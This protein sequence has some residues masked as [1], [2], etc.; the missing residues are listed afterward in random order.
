L[1]GPLR[2]V[3]F[4]PPGVGKGTQAKALASKLGAIWVSTGEALRAVSSLDTDEGRHIKTLVE[5]G[6]LIPDELVTDIVREGIARIVSIGDGFILDGYPRTPAQARQ[7]DEILASNDVSLHQ[8][9]LLEAPSELLI[10]RLLRRA[11]VEG[12]ADDTGEV[13][14]RRLA[15]YE[16]ELEQ[17]VSHYEQ[18]GTLVRVDGTADPETVTTTIA[19]HLVSAEA[20][21][22]CGQAVPSSGYGAQE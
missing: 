11:T 17:L 18:T 2:A 4:G 6:E 21:R 10:E 14:A 1:T 7:L 3:L 12:R 20:V 22:P 9:V 19:Q 16:A 8:A 15:I 5:R 13:I